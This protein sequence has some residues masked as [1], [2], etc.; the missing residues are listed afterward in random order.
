MAADPVGR[1]AELKLEAEK[2]S[3]ET[4]VRAIGRITTAT[5]AMLENTLRDLIP[6]GKRIVLDL[7]NVDHIDSTG[8]GALVSVY[9]HAR[10]T[11]CDLEFANPKQHIRDL[12]KVSGLASVFESRHSIG[13]LWE[14]WSRD[15]GGTR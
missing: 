11:Y 9:M 3:S 14:A 10:R 13:V 7:T 4:I 5:S 8:L 6:A 15:S 1:S 12:F 2:R